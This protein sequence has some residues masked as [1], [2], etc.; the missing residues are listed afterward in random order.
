[1]VPR[2]GLEPALDF[3][4]RI[5][6]S[7]FAQTHATRDDRTQYKLLILLAWI[8]P[9]LFGFEYT[10]GQIWDKNRW[11]PSGVFGRRLHTAALL[12]NKKA[13]KSNVSPPQKSSRSMRLKRLVSTVC[14]R[15]KSGMS[16]LLSYKPH[17]MMFS[18]RI[19]LNSVPPWVI[20]VTVKSCSPQ[21]SDKSLSL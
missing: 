17:P 8:C 2:A 10:V 16:S 5:L 11:V 19:P 7:S 12:H 14:F 3:S 15:P 4:K 1:M 9:V 18:F 20:P 13:K 21:A 6:S